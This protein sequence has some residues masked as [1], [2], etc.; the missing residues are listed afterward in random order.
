[1]MQIVAR[2]VTLRFAT[3]VIATLILM[4]IAVR[5]LLML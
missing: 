2:R 1:M 4:A 3:F 5:D